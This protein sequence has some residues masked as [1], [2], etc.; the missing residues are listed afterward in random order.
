MNEYQKRDFDAQQLIADQFIKLGYTAKLIEQQNEKNRFDIVINEKYQVSKDYNQNI[1]LWEYPYKTHSNISSY[2]RA[3]IYKK[4]FVSNKMKVINKSKIDAKLKEIDAFNNELNETQAKYENRNILFLTR[5]LPQA[6]KQLGK[7]AEIITGNDN[8]S[9]YITKNGLMYE[10]C[11]Q[12]DGYIKQDITLRYY[13][14]NNTSTLDAFIKLSD[15][16]L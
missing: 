4:H 13:N 5:D 1:N 12:Q 11:I 9:G 8:K 10:Y 15:N 2:K 3:E 7:K 16:K 6:I 14:D